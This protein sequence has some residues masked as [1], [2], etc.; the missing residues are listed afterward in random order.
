MTFPP[1]CT[2]KPIDMGDGLYIDG[3]EDDQHHYVEGRT[4]VAPG[5]VGDAPVHWSDLVCE[6]CGVIDLGWTP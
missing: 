1:L 5:P 4:Y 2:G 3:V 6:K